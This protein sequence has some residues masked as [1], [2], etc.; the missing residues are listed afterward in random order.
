VTEQLLLNVQLHEQSTF[1]TFT[2]GDNV[3]VLAALKQAV[4]A[5]GERFVYL[6]GEAG[7]G[8]SHLLQACCHFAEKQPARALYLPLSQAQQLRPDVLEGAQTFS[9]ICL[10]DVDAISGDAAWEEA[11]FHLYNNLR[12]AECALVVSAN[13][14]PAALPIKLADLRSRLSWGLAFHVEGL[15][16]EDK[17][18]NLQLRASLRGF[19]MSAEV[20]KFILQRGR[21]DM[22][23]LIDA[24]DR[25]DKASLAEQ[26]KLTIP[27]VKE[28]LGF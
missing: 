13:V 20:A 23:S 28:V 17:L 10:D 1:D 14:A 9:L 22:A 7:V 8:R 12:D 18:S 11:L 2:A 15:S 26:R 25:L 27:F 6:F 16:D 5:Q 4:A 24:F 21:R 19:E 3:Q